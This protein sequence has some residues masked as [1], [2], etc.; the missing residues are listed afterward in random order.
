MLSMDLPDHEPADQAHDDE[1][2]DA[3]TAVASPR[4]S[5]R[6]RSRA[7]VGWSSAVIS[8]RR[9]EGQHDQFDGG[10][11]P[12][13]HPQRAGQHEQPPARLGGDPHAPRH[14]VD[15]VRAWRDGGRIRGR[16]GT[17]SG[18]RRLGRRRGELRRGVRY[19]VRRFRQLLTGDGERAQRTVARR[20]V[21]RRAVGRGGV[22]VPGT[23]Q[24]IRVAGLPQ[25][26]RRAPSRGDL[27]RGFRTAALFLQP[28]R[29]PGQSGTEP[30]EPPWHSSTCAFLFPL[31]RATT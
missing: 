17:F 20:S 26:A 22:R 25:G 14:R 12:H 8:S 27:H 28:L 15:R 13:Q 29:Q 2:A 31:P 23:P 4:G 24:L 19:P 11:D 5:P 9:D 21:V 18:G 3:V 6:R 1:A 16:R 10:D 7:T 30:A